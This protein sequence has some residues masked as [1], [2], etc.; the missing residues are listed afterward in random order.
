MEWKYFETRIHTRYQ[1]ESGF[2]TKDVYK[3]YNYEL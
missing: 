1:R 3:N 2:C